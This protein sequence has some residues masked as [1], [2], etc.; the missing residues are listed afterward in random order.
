MVLSSSDEIER[1]YRSLP[2]A[3]KDTPLTRGRTEG[4]RLKLE[5]LQPT[6]AYKIRAAWTA[7]SR[8]DP[9]EAQ[10]G[11]A[12]SSSGN[13][14]A[15]FTWA[16]HRLGI[17]AHLVLTPQVSG[18]KVALAQQYPCTLHR[19][20]DR[21][22]ARF[23]LLEQLSQRGIVTIDHRL[24]PQVFLG[25]ATI[26]W[27]CAAEPY[28]FERVLIPVSTG[29]LAIGVASALRARGFR[30]EIVA[31]QADGNPTVYHSWQAGR[32]VASEH[33]STCCDAL[34]A[35]SLPQQA[36]DLL[37]QR[38]DNVLLVQEQ[39]VQR[40][41]GYLLH[42]EGLL[43]ETGGAVGMAAILEGQVPAAGTLLICSGRNIENR[44]LRHCL[45][46]YARDA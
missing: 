13:F 33:V 44:L 21:Y 5:T 43:V 24:D 3:L 22:E 7:L 27:E 29:G 46:L 12:L 41:V 36:Y 9:K 30:G 32:P 38:L 18:R 40:A 20:Q 4:L 28:D 10:R 39:S 45:D 11:V 35:T 8:I 23:E 42:E 15:A 14:A 6:G 19:C 1:A 2:V 16:A 17:P 37:R 25:H 26:G 34:T 31:V